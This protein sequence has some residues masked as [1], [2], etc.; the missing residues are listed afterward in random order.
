MI[1][2]T[3]EQTDDKTSYDKK[4]K[5][6]Q[7]LKVFIIDGLHKKTKI[8]LHIF[9]CCKQS[10]KQIYLEKKKRIHRENSGR[11]KKLP[12]IKCILNI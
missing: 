8:L 6:I 3:K 4:K 2:V 1:N 5:N 11:K 12:K 10:T 7:K 9:V